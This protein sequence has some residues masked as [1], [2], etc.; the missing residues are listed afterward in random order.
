LLEMFHFQNCNNCYCY[1][2]IV[3]LIQRHSSKAQNY[4]VTGLC[5][6]VSSF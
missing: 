4:W 5:S 2:P 3:L 1:V 6:E